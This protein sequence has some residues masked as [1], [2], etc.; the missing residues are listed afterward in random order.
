MVL[1]P[2]LAAPHRS[3]YCHHDWSWIMRVRIR[4]PDATKVLLMA[5]CGTALMKTCHLGNRL[6]DILDKSRRIDF[7]GSLGATHL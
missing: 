3:I 4:R 2:V 5:V 1:Y 7:L 6:F